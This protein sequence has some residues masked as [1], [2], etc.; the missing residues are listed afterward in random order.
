MCQATAGGDEPLVREQSRQAARRTSGP[1][2]SAVSTEQRP[3][4]HDGWEQDG[5]DLVLE[6]EW[7]PEQYQQHITRV[8]VDTLTCSRAD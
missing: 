2:G 7:P 5:L 8:L 4:Q 1:I 6:R 3:N